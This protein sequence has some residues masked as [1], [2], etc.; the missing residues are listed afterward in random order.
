NLG[1]ADEGEVLGPEEEDLPLARVVLV[2]DLLELLALLEADGG[3]EVERGKLVSDAQHC[4]LLLVP[5]PV[6]RSSGSSSGLPE[7]G[8]WFRWSG[9]FGFRLRSTG[10]LGPGGHR[11][12]R[13]AG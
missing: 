13:V 9:A 2:G 7:L 6:V 8:Y 12:A 3:L 4:A 1:R 10:A 5:A 11:R